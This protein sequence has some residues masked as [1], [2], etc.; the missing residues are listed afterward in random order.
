M[1]GFFGVVNFNE[2]ISIDDEISIKKGIEAIKYRGP[3]QQNIL[4][5]E[6]YCFGFNR[7]SII[8]LKA[9][10]QP[11]LT[12]DKTVITMVMGKPIIIKILKKICYQKDKFKTNTDVEVVLHGYA[13]G[14]MNRIN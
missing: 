2:K 8:D 3:D 4:S 10:N 12:P 13:N 9:E 5:D 7:L 6:N 14:E 11:Y 1:C